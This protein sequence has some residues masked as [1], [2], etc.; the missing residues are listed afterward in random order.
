MIENIPII[1]SDDRGT[2]YD[3]D[4]LI[5]IARHKDSITADHT[6][7]TE[8]ETIYLVKGKIELTINEK[9]Q[10][11]KA[12]VKFDIPAGAYHKITAITDVEFLKKVA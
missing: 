1:K 9:T 4:K 5:F 7:V 10:I 8:S 3:C 11:I 12:P 2:V 6:H